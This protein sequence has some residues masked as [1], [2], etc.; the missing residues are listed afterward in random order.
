MSLAQSTHR[1]KH[2]YGDKL[3]LVYGSRRTTYRK[4]HDVAPL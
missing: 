4:F 3:A 1:G 2:M